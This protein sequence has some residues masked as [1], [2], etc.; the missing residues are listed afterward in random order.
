MDSCRHEHR[1]VDDTA[2]LPDLDVGRVH[3]QVADLSLLTGPPLLELLVEPGGYARDLRGADLGAAEL[4]GDRSDLARRDALDVHLGQ[5]QL[6]RPFAAHALLQ[7][8]RI[9]RHVARLRHLQGHVAGARGDGL[10]LIA[11]G[12][13]APLVGPFVRRGAQHLFAF[14]LH[15]E[16]QQRGERRGH[17]IGPMLGDEFQNVVQFVT[18]FLASH[19]GLLLM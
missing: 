10:G 19:V 7:G 3:G 4:F 5:G 14:K 11:V 6:Q 1:T 2:A 12:V 17:D 18:M 16:V 15:G 13:S 9:E 8:R